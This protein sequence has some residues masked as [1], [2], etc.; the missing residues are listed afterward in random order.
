[1]LHIMKSNAFM[2]PKSKHNKSISVWCHLRIEKQQKQLSFYVTSLEILNKFQI[3][4]TSHFKDHSRHR[5]GNHPKYHSLWD[6]KYHFHC[7][8]MDRYATPDSIPD[9]APSAIVN[10]ILDDIP[11]S[12]E[13]SSQRSNHLQLMLSFQVRSQRCWTW[14]RTYS[15]W[16]IAQATLVRDTRCW[17]CFGWLGSWTS[18]GEWV[19]L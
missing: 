9:T 14:R 8:H 6:L 12:L 5:L 16:H 4:F 15:I 3:Q 18:P 7:Q 1:M 2:S 17:L 10:A 13:I 19:R 11:E